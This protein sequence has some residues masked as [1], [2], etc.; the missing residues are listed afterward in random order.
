M[1]PNISFILIPSMKCPFYLGKNGKKFSN[2][3]SA[4]L[5]LKGSAKCPKISN[6]YFHT[7]LALILLFLQLFL[8]IL[9]YFVEWQTE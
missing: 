9:K 8:K 7:F 6:T 2:T 4:D 3:P 5:A 1:E